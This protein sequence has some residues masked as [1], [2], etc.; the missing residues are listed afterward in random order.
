[1]DPGLT[2]SQG[3]PCKFKYKSTAWGGHIVYP[4]FYGSTQFDYCVFSGDAYKRFL[5]WLVGK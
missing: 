4:E 3:Q 5:S 2:D 1:M